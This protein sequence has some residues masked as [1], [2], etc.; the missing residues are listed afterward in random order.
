MILDF[1]SKLVLSIQKINTNIQIIDG[2]L[3]KI[4]RMTSARFLL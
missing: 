1:I 2:P 3:F 4:Y